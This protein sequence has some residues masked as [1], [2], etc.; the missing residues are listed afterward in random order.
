[1]NSGC[2]PLSRQGE[3]LGQDVLLNYRTIVDQ[4][5]YWK[6]KVRE[7]DK[8]TPKPS[9]ATRRRLL[10]ACQADPSNLTELLSYFEDSDDAKLS[11]KQMFDAE[12]ANPAQGGDWQ[13]Q[14]YGWLKE[15]TRFY[16]SELA[17]SVNKAKDK[18]GLSVTHEEDIGILAKVDWPTAGP[19]LLSMA[20][21]GQQKTSTLAI[22][23]LYQHAMD[24]GDAVKIE[25]YRNRL[26]SI[27][28]DKTSQPGARTTAC[29]SLTRSEWTGRD[30]WYLSLFKDET[31]QQLGQGDET[32][33]PLWTPVV[34]DPEKW[35]PVMTKLVESKDASVHNAAVSCLMQFVGNAARK[36]AHIPLL[37][38]LSDAAWARDSGTDRTSLISALGTVEIPESVPNL[39]ALAINDKDADLRWVAASALARYKVKE[40][41][42]VIRRVLEQEGRENHRVALILGLIECGGLSDDEAVQDLEAYVVLISTPEATQRYLAA[43]QTIGEPLPIPVSIGGILARGY[44]IPESCLGKLIDRV[45][46]LESTNPTLAQGLFEILRRWDKGL[47]DVELL[48][49]IT[50]GTASSADIVDALEK[51]DRLKENNLSALSAMT[52]IHGAAGAIAL[53]ILQNAAGIESALKGNDKEERTALLAAARLTSTRLPIE[54]VNAVF[55]VKDQNLNTAAE[56]YLEADDSPEAQKALLARHPNESFIVGWQPGG[57]GPINVVLWTGKQFEEKLRKEI[58]DSD[59]N[60]TIIARLPFYG[61]M[62]S[63]LRIKNGV[64]TY[65]FYADKAW[66][67]ERSLTKSEV[68]SVMD[69]TRE[70][71]LAKIG[72]LFVVCDQNGCPPTEFLTLKRSGGRRFSVT[73]GQNPMPADFKLQTL[74]R[75]LAD[76]GEMTTHYVMEKKIKGVELLVV[77]N[78][79]KVVGAAG[80]GRELWL[81]TQKIEAPVQAEAVIESLTDDDEDE[82]SEEIAKAERAAEAKK[83]LS[84][85]QVRKLVNG[86]LTDQ[87]FDAPIDRATESMYIGIQLPR[88]T[89]Q[90]NENMAHAKIGDSVILA[91]AAIEPGLWKVTGADGMVRVSKEGEYEDPIVSADGKWIIADK[92]ENESD[93]VSTIVRINLETLK[94]Y[95]VNIPSAY[96]LDL[97]AMLPFPGKVLVR[98]AKRDWPG[99]VD[100]IGPASPEFYL[101]D[102]STG[103]TELVDGE[104]QPLMIREDGRLQSTG[105]QDEIWAAIPDETNH[106][107][108]VGRYNFKTFSF[109]TTMV[110]PHIV[111]NGLNMVVDETEGKIYVVYQGHLLRLPLQSITK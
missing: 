11:V 51:R 100:K 40:A 104:F 92:R 61:G 38:W 16:I 87:I 45:R 99:A 67:R 4:Y 19:L 46:E 5:D 34:D 111:F 73:N 33:R 66:Y 48:R 60:E 71:S 31:L 97:F 74:F 24:T 94:E 58:Q 36:D 39:I 95:P 35:I 6:T 8:D 26:K 32:A 80:N 2:R 108:K 72:P 27:V 93:T 56:M 85:F 59:A 70:D 13:K 3:V 76:K 28:A 90:N 37:P 29:N 63:V 102:P 69:A 88:V 25:Q 12:R 20:Q 7:T 78:S 21:T 49:R 47:V 65:S 79:F 101:L 50:K 86:K 54:E 18:S 96:V 83:Q 68:Q 1:V 9:L 41:A 53:V 81:T 52:E 64:G 22:T 89:N 14:V 82:N 15:H 42:Q 103:K 57:Q 62:E 105:Q 106:E 10:E 110:I 91:R 98:R 109:K 84:G 17:L 77:D 107:T 55:A 30:D 75:D 23:Y 44:N 43:F